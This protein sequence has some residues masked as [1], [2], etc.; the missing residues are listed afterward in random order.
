M[1]LEYRQTISDAHAKN[2][3][4]VTYNSYRRE[5]Y[6]GGEGLIFINLNLNQIQP[7]KYGKQ[8]RESF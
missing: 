4:A 7:S 3:F 8:K 5:I 1:S 2:I 6:T